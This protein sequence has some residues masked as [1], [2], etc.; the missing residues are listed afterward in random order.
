MFDADDL[1]LVLAAGHFETGVPA[2]WAEGNW[3]EDGD[4][5]SDDLITALATGKYVCGV[6]FSRGV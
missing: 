4:F 2:A 6:D 5:D 1:M 3:D